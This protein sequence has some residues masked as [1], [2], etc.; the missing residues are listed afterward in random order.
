[1]AGS[2]TPSV[3][4]TAI[5]GIHRIAAGPQRVEP[6]LGGDADGWLA[7]APRRPM[8]SGRWLRRAGCMAGSLDET[9]PG[10]TPGAAAEAYSARSGA[11][12]V[13]ALAELLDHL[14]IEGR[15]CRPACGR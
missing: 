2:T 6:R 8:I 3:S 5:G 7:T 4:E 14:S 13:A 1:M 15:E 11:A 12:A 9:P 10:S